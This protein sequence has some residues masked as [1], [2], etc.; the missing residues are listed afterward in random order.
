[1]T[2]KFRSKSKKQPKV[3][4]EQASPALSVSG[5]KHKLHQLPDGRSAYSPFPDINKKNIVSLLE[6]VTASGRRPSQVFDDWAE[7]SNATLGSLPGQFQAW[8][9]KKPFEDTLET[10]Q[11]FDRLRSMYQPKHFERFAEA[12]SILLKTPETL[13]YYD[14][15]GEIYMDWGSP[16]RGIGQFFTPWSIVQ[17]MSSMT[18][19]NAVEEINENVKRA[20]HGNILAESMLLASLMIHDPVIA[21]AWFVGRIIPTI[22]NDVEKLKVNDP[23]CGSGIMFLG[24]AN[25]LP[26]WQVQMGLVQFY[27]ADIDRSC[28]LMSMLNS[29][30]YGLNGFYS[31]WIVMEMERRLAS[32]GRGEVSSEQSAVDSVPEQE[33]DKPPPEPPPAPPMSKERE[34]FQ[35]AA[36]DFSPPTVP[37][38]KTSQMNLFDLLR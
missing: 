9:D 6:K 2:I 30:L 33:E 10:K 15:V 7:L 22:I 35:E 37:K 13:G 12:F 31:P 19:G 11:L 38:G 34:M 18:V 27:G 4:K 21:Q 17:A 29:R 23:A 36:A 25:E 3:T 8:L 5:P 1:M 16:G 32:W 26:W 24:F 20:I 28:W 14:I